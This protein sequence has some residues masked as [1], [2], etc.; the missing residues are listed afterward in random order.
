VVAGGHCIAPAYILDQIRRSLRNLRIATID[1]YYLHNPEQQLD[2]IPRERF[3]ERMRDAFAALEQ[4]VADE[5]IGS[6]GCATW[7]GFRVPQENRSHLE[8]AELVA[9]A[10]EVAG[11]DHHFRAVQLPLNLA[12]PE[13]WRSPTQIGATGP[14]TVLQAAADHGLAVF[15]SAS[16]MQGQLT[17]NLPPQ[18]R[19]AFPQCASDAQC[20]AAFVRGA[21]SVVSALIGIRTIAHLE[22]QLAAVARQ[23]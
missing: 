5:L 13:A 7:N 4:A 20:A 6:Y 3:R 1:I 18:I 23:Q 15:A 22:E 8:L 2:A 11:D 16:L 21:P 14:A 9:I 19:E 12:M 10:R 17:R